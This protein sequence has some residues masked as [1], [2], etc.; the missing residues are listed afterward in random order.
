MRASGQWRTARGPGSI[1]PF[2]GE[3]VDRQLE[4]G[5]RL[6]SLDRDARRLPSILV[7][8]S[9]VFASFG[10]LDLAE[11]E[12]TGMTWATNGMRVG[13][14]VAACALAV[15]VRRRPERS[16]AWLPVTLIEAYAMTTFLLT[17]YYDSLPGP[18]RS[19]QF[20]ILSVSMLIYVPNR[21][22]P[23]LGVV[24]VG[25]VA[26]GWVGL[27]SI[28]GSSRL[29][30][31][32]I[33]TLAVAMFVNGSVA[34][35]LQR[36]RRD[37]YL[38]FVHEQGARVTLEH[39]VEQRAALQGELEWLAAHDALTDLLN[40]RAF[41]EQAAA[42]FATSRR[43]GRPVSVLVIDADD[44]KAIND[45]Y[46]HHTGD[47]VIR[48]VAHLCRLHLRADDVVGRLGGEEFA[49]V[50]P[51][52]G[53]D[54]AREIAD[55]LRERIADVAVDAPHGTVHLTVSIGVSECRPWEETIHDSLQ[56][57]DAAMYE[58]KGSGRNRVVPS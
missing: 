28:D 24:A 18:T 25:S 27:Q 14:V 20:A 58:A 44:F 30:A 23:A 15:R 32:A 6:H 48:T 5:F 38:S 31:E 8:S 19:L 41:F 50:M 4:R 53:L 40:R 33:I 2:T 26:F 21:L 49:V 37:E 17:A 34:W 56:R 12:W 10:L 36:S 47:E 13:L 9:I 16:L 57:A 51:A 22:L 52:T 45:R 7:F 54:R 42:A 11:P 43:T 35:M 29:D 1:H 3:F 46:G 39:E 55:R